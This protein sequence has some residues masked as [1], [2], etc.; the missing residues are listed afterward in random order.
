MGSIRAVVVDPSAA[1]GRLALKD[2]A[3][4]AALP[5]ETLVRVKAFSLNLGEVR[6]AQTAE[7]GWRP[8]WDLA[9]VV[10]RPAADGSGPSVG[11]RV[12]AIMGSAGS[13]AEEVAVPNLALAELPD[14]VSFAEA[15]TLPVAGLTALFALE[16]GGALLGRNVLVTG[17]SG[18][19]GIFACQLARHGGAHVVGLV[20]RSERARYAHE[21]HAHEVVVGENLGG[22]ERF[23][24]Y[25]LILESV[26][27]KVLTQAL[28]MLKSGCGMCVLL[29]A[30]SGG[31]VTFDASR[32]YLTGGVNLFGFELNEALLHT[33]GSVGLSRLVQMLDMGVLR[34]RI[35]VQRPW[36]ET[37]TTAHELFHERKIAGKAVML[38]E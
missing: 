31:E 32:F 29:G 19:V 30:S 23:A 14:S 34:P 5:F 28:T 35:E 7:P 10:E 13:W 38:V 24:P 9:G 25:D 15:A 17:A 37:A 1:R 20:R 4:P 36:Q 12:V 8:G 18:G 2:V 11:A 22:A 3:R 33:P 27:G 26:G 21:A 6:R 16:K